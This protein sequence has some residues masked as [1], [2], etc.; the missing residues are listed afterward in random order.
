[1]E[2]LQSLNPNRSR[3][4]LAVLK[5]IVGVLLLP[6]IYAITVAF[7]NESRTIE[8]LFFNSFVIGI[9]SFLVFYLFV[10][11]PDVIYQ[12][13]QKITEAAFHFLSP[14]FKFASYVMPVYGIILFLI[15]GILSLVT[16]NPFLRQFFMFMIGFSFIF[17]M[18]F[19]AKALRSH[20]NDFLMTNYI[21]SFSFIYI[22][23]ISLLALGFSILYLPFSW[24]TFF[25]L[26]FQITKHIF[27]SVFIQLF[28]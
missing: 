16:K 27:S 5:F 20:K 13:E 1:M 9:I 25:R 19:S 18:V 8:K 23:N 21:F 14:L 12:K 24:F 4:A 26:T 10:Y 7:I 28:L 15:Y 17:H 6:V 2:N 22:V 11:A 3:K